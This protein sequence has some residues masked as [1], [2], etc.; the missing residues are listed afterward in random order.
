MHPAGSGGFRRPVWIWQPTTIG[1]TL[2]VRLLSAGFVVGDK[3]IHGLLDALFHGMEFVVGLEASQLF[4]AGGLFELAVGLQLHARRL[5]RRH[6]PRPAAGTY[7]DNPWR[8]VRRD[9]LHT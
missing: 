8:A 2:L 6:D 9:N 7:A 3:P 1:P 5:E 4:V